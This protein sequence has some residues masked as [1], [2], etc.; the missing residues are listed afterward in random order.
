MREHKPDLLDIFADRSPGWVAA[1]DGTVEPCTRSPSGIEPPAAPLPWPPRPPELADWPLAC[2][3]RW[4]RLANE[5]E[6]R[7]AP[8]P[9]SESEA[10]RRVKA[11]MEAD[12]I[13]QK[14]NIV[15]ISATASERKRAAWEVTTGNCVDVMAQA[16]PGSIDL[17]IADPP[18]NYDVDYGDHYDDDRPREEYLKWCQSW[19]AAGVKTLAI[20]G[21]MWVLINDENAAEFKIMLERAGLHCRNWII[22]FE[23]FGVN[24]TKKFNRTHRH[25]LYMVRDPERFTFNAD[26]VRIESAR[27]AVY[28]DKRANPAG[29]IMN[30]VW[31]DIPRLAGTH[32]ERIGGFPTQLPVKLLRRIVECSSNPGGLVLDPFCG[33]GTT[34]EACVNLGR[35]FLGIE[36]SAKFAELARQRLAKIVPQFAC[37]E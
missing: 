25:L 14:R 12:A 37:M 8:F 32:G 36:L 1:P 34:G 31:F 5:L 26:A 17:I 19:I 29:K 13:A 10:F 15:P 18:Y 20:D 16:E 24:C 6:A 22:W 11:E 9:D 4:G 23:S 35:R 7:G 28:H 33:S 2:R 30:D 3:E 27:Q 21:S